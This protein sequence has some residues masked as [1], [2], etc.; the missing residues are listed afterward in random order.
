M[1]ERFRILKSPV[2]RSPRLERMVVEREREQ[3]FLYMLVI[4]GALVVW[5]L[6]MS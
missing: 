2:L 6:V 1:R 5:A 4:G 3:I